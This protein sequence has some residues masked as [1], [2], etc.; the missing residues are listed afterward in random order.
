MSILIYKYGK[1]CQNYP[2]ETTGLH[3]MARFGLLSLL[4]KLLSKPE[5]NIMISADLRDSYGRTLLLLAAESGYDAVAKLLLD[6]D[7]DVNA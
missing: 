4:E 7:A 2:R 6:K 1:Y 3:L 5:R